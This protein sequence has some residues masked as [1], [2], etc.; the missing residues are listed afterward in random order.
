MDETCADY[1]SD[2]YD[3]QMSTYQT[4]LLVLAGLRPT[5]TAINPCK[6]FLCWS[7]FLESSLVLQE[8]CYSALEKATIIAEAI[9]WRHSSNNSSSLNAEEKEDIVDEN[10]NRILH[11]A[12]E[13]VS[14][15]YSVIKSTT[16]EF[17]Q[18]L[19]L[20]SKI[21]VH[22][23]GNDESTEETA[24]ATAAVDR[25]VL[26]AAVSASLSATNIV[27]SLVS[28]IS[29]SKVIEDLAAIADW[30]AP[31]ASD[32][33]FI[34]ADFKS[35]LVSLILELY[36]LPNIELVFANSVE[37][38]QFIQNLTSSQKLDE[39]RLKGLYSYYECMDSL[40]LDVEV[41]QLLKDQAQSVALDAVG[42]N[43]VLVICAV[44]LA[45]RSFN[46]LSKSYTAA[47]PQICDSNLAVIAEDLAVLSMLMTYHAGRHVVHRVICGYF[48]PSIALV[49]ESLSSSDDE[50]SDKIFDTVFNV[51]A[52]AISHTFD[53]IVLACLR[54][55]ADSLLV[56]LMNIDK[57]EYVSR[58]EDLCI[59]LTQI[60]GS[61]E[62]PASTIPE[63]QVNLIA[64]IEDLVEDEADGKAVSIVRRF[65]TISSSWEKIKDHI[66]IS[67]VLR[68]A[69]RLNNSVN[70]VLL[71]PR[72]KINQS[73]I[74]PSLLYVTQWSTADQSIESF[75]KTFHS[76]LPVQYSYLKMMAIISSGHNDIVSKSQNEDVLS[77]V[78]DT[79]II[80]YN[81]CQHVDDRSYLQQS[82]AE[83]A[84]IISRLVASSY[85]SVSILRYIL[86][87]VYLTPLAL[88]PILSLLSILFS[89][90][91]EAS[92]KTILDSTLLPRGLCSNFAGEFFTFDDEKD[93]S[94]IKC[95]RLLKGLVDRNFSIESLII[96]SV[97]SASDTCNAVGLNLAHRFIVARVESALSLC[98]YLVSTLHRYMLQLLC[99]VNAPDPD[100]EDVMLVYRILIF[101]EVLCLEDTCCLAL[102]N[103]G[104]LEPIFHGLR[105]KKD[106]IILVSLQCATTIHRTLAR[107]VSQ[108]PT[109]TI[110]D[111]E[112]GS[113][114]IATYI[115]HLIEN[116]GRVISTLL[117]AILKE[118]KELSSP[119]LIEQ[120]V[121]CLQ[122]LHPHHVKSFLDR[123][124][125]I[126]E[127]LSFEFISVKLWLAFEDSFQSLYEASDICKL[128]NAAS[129]KGDSAFNLTAEDISKIF[130]ESHANFMCAANALKA[131][132]GLMILAY[133][134]HWITLST[135]AKAMRSSLA[136]P[137]KV[138]IRFQR[139]YTM[140]AT[141]GVLNT[142]T[143][144][145]RNESTH[146]LDRFHGDVRDFR[147]RRTFESRHALSSTAL[148]ALVGDLT[149]MSRFTFAK[150]EQYGGEGTVVQSLD[151]DVYLD[152]S[153][154][155]RSF[156]ISGDTIL[157][158]WY[159]YR[160]FKH[161]L[162][163]AS[164]V[165]GL[166]TIHSDLRR[167]IV[168]SETSA[169]YNIYHSVDL[170]QPLLSKN[171]AR[172][173]FAV[174]GE[175]KFGDLSLVDSPTAGK[176]RKNRFSVVSE[177][178]LTGEQNHPAS[179]AAESVNLNI[180]SASSATNEPIVQQNVPTQNVS[181][182]GMMY[183]SMMNPS[184]SSSHLSLPNGMSFPPFMAHTT[185]A[186][187]NLGPGMMMQP[188]FPGT[189][190]LNSGGRHNARNFNRKF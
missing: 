26:D 6:T 64:D 180:P 142:H 50:T 188:P 94:D 35:L 184:G 86:Q 136:D 178:S 165:F 14:S 61:N 30:S 57:V 116:M 179:F 159:D 161:R 160:D 101:I 106:G 92:A 59:L 145:M 125:L 81:A 17:V 11:T 55:T 144:P 87:R 39:G 31:T 177:D 120:C 158:K 167:G 135:L 84:L 36:G 162:I 63:L 127:G 3:S 151:D 118:F 29:I 21:G 105:V 16:N 129:S 149:K 124:A 102:C 2:S 33:V 115:S 54:S 152:L 1:N 140:W 121:I 108:L 114:D 25:P 8:S 80:L 183:S 91:E 67:D 166:N 42:D 37:E 40:H 141:S 98:S 146:L 46:A 175:S 148:R 45:E 68:A 176:K 147:G 150:E 173:K 154:P 107:I 22:D 69:I 93:S 77:S 185:S 85:D 73:Y 28:L 137:K 134:E 171:V 123:L 164:Q 43:M 109:Q 83:C 66:N 5:S 190:V 174:K 75:V 100:E 44:T 72:M 189:N 70:S 7:A 32:L 38:L 181:N 34:S 82:K 139:V 71:E 157:R 143:N 104:V 128:A 74:T 103:C 12:C 170:S 10:E 96:S 122:V 182:A 56:T 133:T 126:G 51:L 52:S 24:Q 13:C 89:I 113:V 99:S 78:L 62:P 119:N 27:A 76:V 130:S 79:Y 23:D 41:V 163:Q 9:S 48:L 19:K 20:V 58:A 168:S 53:P 97:Y 156:D 111:S 60:Q 138:V 18:N 112:H 187:M 169:C 65:Q 186:T 172:A 117:P 155:Y 90:S 47:S 15:I 110:G 153:G 4:V 95:D 88:E 131:I 49:L 132:C